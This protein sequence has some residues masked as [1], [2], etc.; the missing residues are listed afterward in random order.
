MCYSALL[1][2]QVWRRSPSKERPE[3]FS[4]FWITPII[5]CDDLRGSYWF[6]CSKNATAGRI[7]AGASGKGETRSP[8]AGIIST[9]QH[10]P[11]VSVAT[12]A[13]YDD[14]IRCQPLRRATL[15]QVVHCFPELSTESLHSPVTR[16]SPGLN[17][18]LSCSLRDRHRRPAERLPDLP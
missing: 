2:T 14:R 1:R 3:I 5:R 4:S 17:T 15:L 10:L 6:G 9:R 11:L 7:L 8:A 13:T 16:L 12:L 18:E